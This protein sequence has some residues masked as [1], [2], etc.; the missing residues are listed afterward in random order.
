[1]SLVDDGGPDLRREL[2]ELRAERDRLRVENV[3]LSRLLEL[4]G[5]DTTPVAEQ[6]A[7]P[8]GPGGLVSM[9]G[10]GA[11]AT[12]SYSSTTNCPRRRETTTCWPKRRRLACIF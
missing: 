6:L 5:E 3:R 12:L 1:M 10:T 4:R 2:S 7:A 9:A 11:T 8:I